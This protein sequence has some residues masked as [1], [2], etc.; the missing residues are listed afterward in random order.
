MK[1]DEMKKLEALQV[2]GMASVPSERLRSL[3]SWAYEFLEIN[4]SKLTPGAPAPPP[5]FEMVPYEERLN[6]KLS[7]FKGW[8][9]YTVDLGWD[10]SERLYSHERCFGFLMAG[11]LMAR[12]IPPT[13]KAP[14]PP[15]ERYSR[16]IIDGLGVDGID[17]DEEFIRTMVGRLI[18][19][20]QDPRKSEDV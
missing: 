7:D 12:P 9:C 1:T 13:P 3:P 8:K 14:E 10:Y 18:A 5:G 11:G 15:H 19:E 2:R 16:L 6:S 4:L 20:V 17:S